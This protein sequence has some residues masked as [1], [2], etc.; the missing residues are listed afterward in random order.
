MVNQEASLDNGDRQIL[1]MRLLSDF[2]TGLPRDERLC[3]PQQSRRSES[4]MGGRFAGAPIRRG[5]G[6]QQGTELERARRGSHQR[7]S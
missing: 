3:F 4:W 7:V 2:G 6:F 5:G 1:T